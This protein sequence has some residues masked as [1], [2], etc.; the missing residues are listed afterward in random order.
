MLSNKLLEQMVEGPLPKKMHIGIDEKNE[1]TA[2]FS[3]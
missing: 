3:D 1:F 2:A